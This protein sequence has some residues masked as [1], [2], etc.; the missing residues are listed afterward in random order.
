MRK[1]ILSVLATVSLLASLCLLPGCGKAQDPGSED[2]FVSDDEYMI[3]DEGDKDSDT[4][5]TARKKDGGNTNAKTS[6][7][8]KDDAIDPSA[9]QT[10]DGSSGKPAA[11]ATPSQSAGT[12]SGSSQENELP[13]VPAEGISGNSSSSGNESD[14]ELDD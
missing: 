8:K 6:S 13:L 9:A 10:P 5:K 14:I 3:L 1:T 7:D 2:L 11:T 4:G 12:S